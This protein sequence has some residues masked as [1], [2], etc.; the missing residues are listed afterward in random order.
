MKPFWVLYMNQSISA[1][2]SFGLVLFAHGSRNINW[3]NPFDALLHKIHNK[4]PSNNCIE[5]A[6]L[7]LMRPSL[8]E[9][10]ENLVQK[11]CLN[12][13]IA[14]LFLGKGGHIEK[15]LPHMLE[16]I[17]NKYKIQNIHIQIKLL[18]ITGERDNVLD[19]IAYDILQQI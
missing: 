19:F 18:P 9:C 2:N 11:Q 1:K 17:H 7:E 15:D 5:L 10:I 6:F 4:I 8:E 3:R 13:T 12:I 14:P 16:V